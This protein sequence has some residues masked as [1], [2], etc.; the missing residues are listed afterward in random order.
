[1]KNDRGYRRWRDPDEDG[2]A[3]NIYGKTTSTFES[4]D[5][6]MMGRAQIVSSRR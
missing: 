6:R 5:I 3:Q 1:M 2:T 4:N